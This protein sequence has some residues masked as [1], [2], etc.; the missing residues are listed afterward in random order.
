MLAAL[1]V[2]EVGAVVLVDGQAEPAFERA[3]VVAEDVWVFVEVD[4]FEGKLAEA[5]AS[6]GVGGGVGGDAAAAEF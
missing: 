5:F 6:V 2:G 1:G 4:G 3:Q